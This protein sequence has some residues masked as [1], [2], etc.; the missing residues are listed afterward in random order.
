LHS[1]RTLIA[2]AHRNEFRPEF[3]IDDLRIGKRR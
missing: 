2:I 3:L 1:S